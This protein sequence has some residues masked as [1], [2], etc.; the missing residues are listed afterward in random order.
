MQIVATAA[1]SK[2]IQTLTNTI[3]IS[4]SLENTSYL[5]TMLYNGGNKLIY[6]PR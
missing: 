1:E 4:L 2:T 5:L 3:Y 6:N